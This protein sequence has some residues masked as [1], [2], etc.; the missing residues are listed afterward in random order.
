MFRVNVMDFPFT[1]PSR[2]AIEDRTCFSLSASHRPR[3]SMPSSDNMIELFDEGTPFFPQYLLFPLI[4]KL[5]P[6]RLSLL[7]A[8]PDFIELGLI[9]HFIRLRIKFSFDL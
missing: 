6:T 2:L 9:I 5:I 1:S 7:S 8:M 4:Q 3:P